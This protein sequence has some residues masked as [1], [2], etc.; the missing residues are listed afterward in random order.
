[1]NEQKFRSLIECVQHSHEFMDCVHDLQCGVDRVCHHNSYLIAKLLDHLG[2]PMVWVNGLYQCADPQE[3]IHHSWLAN[4]ADEPTVIFE[5]DPHQLRSAGEYEEDLMPGP[6]PDGAMMGADTAVI[7]DPARVTVPEA[8]QQ[9]NWL[10]S[11]VYVLDRYQANPA[12]RPEL[13]R[14]AL[15]EIAADAIGAFERGRELRA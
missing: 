8:M 12:Y 11:S 2:E 5:F 9:R 13:D 7:V 15:D 14:D 4:A 1:M 3:S 6:R 10:V